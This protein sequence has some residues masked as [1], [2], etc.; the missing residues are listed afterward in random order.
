MHETQVL[1]N[2]CILYNVLINIFHQYYSHKDLVSHQIVEMLRGLEMNWMSFVL[3]CSSKRN[4]KVLR[5][6]S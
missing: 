2:M 4:E 5:A 1:K 3:D 6:S